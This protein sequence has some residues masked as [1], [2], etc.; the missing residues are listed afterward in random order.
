M[1]LSASRVTVFKHLSGL[2]P[3]HPAIVAL[4]SISTESDSA[5]EEFERIFK[6]DP[7]LTTDL[8]L[9]ANSAAFGMRTR[10]TTI[11]HALAL[12]GLERVRSLAVNIMLAGYL[13]KQP[14][15]GVR[16]TWLH[17]VAT[18]VI[19]EAL[20]EIYGVSGMYTVG[21]MHDLGRL[22]LLSNRGERYAETLRAEVTG[23]DEAMELE[24]IVCGMNHCDAGA[25][26]AGTW[27]FSEIFQVCMVT[28]HD[29]RPKGP[30][31]DPIELI[32]VACGMADWVGYPEVRWKNI[33]P[34]PP[35]PERAM[36]SPQLEPERLLRLIQQQTAILES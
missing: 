36:K 12:L 29:S 33:Q 31:G 13:Q 11:R 1:G 30:S 25:L 20:G 22:A 14:M 10:V 32:R 5:I 21:L 16:A 35:L 8:L 34:P 26:V 4:T 28:H 9:M 3:I 27:G 17:S 19:A 23:I 7:A 18:A 2:P 6:S 15:D 24:T